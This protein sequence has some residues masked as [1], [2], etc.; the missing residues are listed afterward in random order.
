MP[1]YMHRP[2]PKAVSSTHRMNNNEELAHRLISKAIQARVKD[3]RP[4]MTLRL[5]GQRRISSWKPEDRNRIIPMEKPL[6]AGPCQGT[7]CAMKLGARE[8]NRLNMAKAQQADKQP[9]R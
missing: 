7:I 8:A 4:T 6:V 5:A 3:S 1:P 9:I 2:W